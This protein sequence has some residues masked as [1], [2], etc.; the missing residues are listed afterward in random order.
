MRKL[1]TASAL[2]ALISQT[3]VLAAD[4]CEAIALRDV[5]AKEDP[6]SV[7]KRGEVDGAVT[8]Y[9]V[10]K[11]T[12]EGVFCSHGGYCYPTHV[13][14][15]GQQVEALRLTN[16]KVGARDAFD[17]SD[18]VFY[19]VDVIRTAIS[20]E[21][22]KIDD[23][24]NRLLEIGLC[25]ACAAE[26]A[27]LYVTRPA[28]QCARIVKAALE[29]DPGAVEALNNDP[30]ICPP[31]PTPASVATAVAPS[32]DCQRAR[33]SDEIAICHDPRLAQMDLN[34]AGLYTGLRSVATPRERK[35][36]DADQ[37]NWVNQRRACGPDARCIATSYK[38]RVRNLYRSRPSACD[39][40]DLQQ[41]IGCDPGAQFD[42]E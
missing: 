3:P 32:F 35:F 22:L 29:G 10:N 16:C 38:G 24:D 23:L 17:D 13:L 19:A 27:H 31:D 14:D 12:G 9:R 1:L 26:A 34:L 21:M 30:Q 18:D 5:P 11:K 28:S 2:V 33:Y 42:I 36:L 8:Q 25:S 15:N 39:R 41:P 7:L 20:P 4:I 6:N 37:A 40:P